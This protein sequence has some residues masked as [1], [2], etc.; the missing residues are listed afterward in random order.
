MEVTPFA[1]AL[2]GHLQEQL[3]TVSLPDLSRLRL[4]GSYLI[5]MQSLELS[6]PISPVQ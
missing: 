3:S 6:A 2:R 4:Y 5:T 1:A